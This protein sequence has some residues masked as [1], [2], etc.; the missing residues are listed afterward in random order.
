MYDQ[1]DVKRKEIR[2]LEFLAHGE[3]DDTIYATCQLHT[4]SLIDKS[5]PFFTALSYVWGD[6]SVTRTILLNGLGR[7]VT[8]NLA[9]A[10]RRLSSI[11]RE[12]EFVEAG[13]FRVWAD[14]VCINQD[15]LDERGQ[16]VAMM[17]HLYTSASLVYSF[18]GTDGFI[19]LAMDTMRT[20]AEFLLW[21][22]VREY[23]PAEWLQQRPGLHAHDLPREERAMIPNAC[24]KALE[25]FTRLRYWT[26]MWIFQ[27]IVLSKRLFFICQTGSPMAKKQLCDGLLGLQMLGTWWEDQSQCPL[28]CP[29]SIWL[30][31]KQSVPVI[32]GWAHGQISPPIF[33]KHKPGGAGDDERV[34]FITCIH[35]AF[36]RN[37]EATDP[38]DY[39]YSLMGVID[40]P[41]RPSYQSTKLVEH[42]C[43]D[44][45]RAYMEQTRGTHTVLHI[46]HEAAG[47][48]EHG[49]NPNIPSWVPALHLASWRRLRKFVYFSFA[50]FAAH[51]VF[52]SPNRPRWPS[53]E[54]HGT[55]LR[56]P[57]VRVDALSLCQNH[58]GRFLSEDVRGFLASQVRRH[59]RL[60]LKMDGAIPVERAFLAT[61]LRNA[62]YC[63]PARDLSSVGRIH[64]GSFRGWLEL[65]EGYAAGEALPRLEDGDMPNELRSKLLVELEKNQ[66]GC[67][68]ETSQGYF[69]TGPPD[70]RLGDELCILQGFERLVLLRPRGDQ[71]IFVGTCFVLGLMLGEAKQLVDSGHAMHRTFELVMLSSVVD[72]STALS[73]GD[74]LLASFPSTPGSTRSKRLPSRAPA[75]SALEQ[76]S[77]SESAPSST[78]SSLSPFPPTS[79]KWRALRRFG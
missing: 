23:K 51:H 43:V 47:A 61:L 26:R 60:Y 50:S 28:F 11:A 24:W 58:L 33:L 44:F 20:L 78:S 73:A 56:V 19:P 42:V 67:V 3:P 74:T 21:G 32:A 35:S 31:F 6:A 8:L 40:L 22:M 2:V 10:L 39:Y 53:P 17:G 36:F 79:A 1:L 18:L 13:E 45:A 14:A 76:E 72:A 29:Q 48:R 66:A 70:A 57:G 65:M 27:E 15:N 75:V 55:I 63:D 54:V 64:D 30:R 38:R 34:R 16:Q 5:P 71:H 4:I 41:L 46:L 68:F 12:A 77:R 62:G 25:D 49:R 37:V 9:E 69:G 52:D 59:G 7:N